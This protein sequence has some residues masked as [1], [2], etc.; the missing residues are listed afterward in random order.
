MHVLFEYL[1]ERDERLSV[2]LHVPNR[3]SWIHALCVTRS[4]VG[5]NCWWPWER[6]MST[7]SCPNSPA[8]LLQTRTCG[9][10][11]EVIHLLF[12]FLLFLLPSIFP[13]IIVFSKEPCLLT[14]CP[15][16]DSFSFVIDTYYWR[17]Y[18]FKYCLCITNA[19]VIKYSFCKVNNQKINQN[20]PL[21][22][23][24]PEDIQQKCVFTI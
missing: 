15:R 13:S 18:Y 7:L 16:L 23:P 21:L 9:F 8:Q 19:S 12:N 11:Y 24:I 1:Q 3:L 10:L 20:F 14:M 22:M 2:M 6:V 17:P 5:S 4:W